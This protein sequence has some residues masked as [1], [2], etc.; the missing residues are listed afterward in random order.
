M[1]ASKRKKKK[2]RKRERE[3]E[4][5]GGREREGEREIEVETNIRAALL[6]LASAMVRHAHVCSGVT[7]DGLH[8]GAHENNEYPER[9]KGT[10]LNIKILNYSG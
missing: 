1:E 7:A 3:R 4:R 6:V 8:P 9:Q 10:V 2:E 5:E